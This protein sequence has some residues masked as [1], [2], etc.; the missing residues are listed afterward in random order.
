MPLV[1]K[2]GITTSWANHG[3]PPSNDTTYSLTWAQ[4][5]KIIKKYLIWISLVYG[6]VKWDSLEGFSK[7]VNPLNK[8][9]LNASTSTSY[10]QGQICLLKLSTQNSIR[11]R[12]LLKSRLTG[13]DPEGSIIRS[14]CSKWWWIANFNSARDS[15]S[16]SAHCGR[17]DKSL[18]WRG[19]ISRGGKSR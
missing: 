18:Y 11:K 2:A 15:I 14:H 4:S 10:Y 7:A 9:V 1:N 17:I 12:G 19:F 6:I 3:Q 5:L 16:F 13:W 8:K